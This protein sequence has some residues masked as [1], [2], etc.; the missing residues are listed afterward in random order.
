MEIEIGNYEI[1]VGD[2]IRTLNGCIAKVLDIRGQHKMITRTGHAA[3]TPA[4]Y[5]LDNEKKYSISKPY[6]KKYSSNILDLL[7]VGDIVN[8]NKIEDI[9]IG[10]VECADGS[11]DLKEKDIR[12]IM[13]KEEYERNCYNVER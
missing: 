11:Y 4:R 9:S 6:I 8:G 7:E 10:Y 5:F 3:V 2:Y 12:T 13:T 1:K